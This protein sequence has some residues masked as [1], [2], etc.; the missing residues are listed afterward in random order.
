[1]AF[2]EAWPGRVE[3]A[4][5]GAPVPFLGREALLK[6]KRA[7]GCAKDLVDAALLESTAR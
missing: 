5:A 2:D 3:V 4:V 6:N 7:T 1:L